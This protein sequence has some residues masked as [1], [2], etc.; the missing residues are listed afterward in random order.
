MPPSSADFYFSGFTKKFLT[1]QDKTSNTPIPF[2]KNGDDLNIFLKSTNG[3][4]FKKIILTYLKKIK[5][6]VFKHSLDGKHLFEKFVNSQATANQAYLEDLY[7]FVGILE[8]AQNERIEKDR[9][10]NA[11]EVLFSEKAYRKQIYFYLMGPIVEHSIQTLMI[12]AD[13]HKILYDER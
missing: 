11:I 7:F 13:K 4:Q 8:L 2:P 10:K 1:S 12:W 3:F 9:R 5:T 6:S